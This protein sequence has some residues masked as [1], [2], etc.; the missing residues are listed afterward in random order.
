MKHVLS[1]G[2]AFFF[3][4]ITS[5]LHAEMTNQVCMATPGWP[6]DRSDLEA[7]PSLVRG[8]LNNGMRYV[9]KEN[10]EPK[11]RVAMY[12]LINAGSLNEL[13]SQRGVA[14]FLEHMLFNGSTHFKPGE[15]VKFFQDIG[16]NFG[17]DTNAFTSFDQTAYNI[18]LPDGTS[19]NL[20]KGFLVLSD[21]ARRALLLESE[22]DRERGVILSEKRSRDSVGYRA[23][24]KASEFKYD[25]T[26]LATRQPIGLESVIKDADRELLKSFYDTW[27]RTDNMVVV[28]VGDVSSEQVKPLLEDAFS[29]LESPEDAP[30]C[31]DFGA[32][33]HAEDKAYY[34]YDPDLGSTNVSIDSIW[35]LTRRNDSKAMQ[36]EEVIR[37]A[38][39]MMMQRRLNKLQESEGELFSGIG[40]YSGDMVRKLGYSTLSA[41]VVNGKWQEGLEYLEN[42][43]RQ[44]LEYG[45]QEQEFELVKKE[46][47]SMLERAVLTADTKPSQKIARSIMRAFVSD[48]V[49]MSPQQELDLYSAMLDDLTMTEINAGIRKDWSQGNRLVSV[50]G[51]T[52]IA[53]NKAEAKILDQYLLAK[54]K[55]VT[56]YKEDIVG[57]FPYLTIPDV[58]DSIVKE[59]H[60][61]ESIDAERIIYA[62]NVSLILKPTEFNANT[63]QLVLDFGSGKLSEP[64]PGM[65]MLA[66]DIV[67]DS[68]T[69][70][71]TSTALDELLAGT[72][73]QLNFEVREDSFRLSGSSLTKDS[74]LLFQLL[75]TLLNDPG[76]RERSYTIARNQLKE[77]YDSIA[78]EAEGAKASGVERFFAGGDERVG[79]P[80]WEDVEAISLKEIEAWLVPQFAAGGVEVAVVGDFDPERIK[81]LARTY[82]G[83]L[84][85]REP[86]SGTSSTLTFPRGQQHVELVNSQIDKS[87]VVVAWPTDDF[88]DINR[89]RR[90]NVLAGIFRERLRQVVREKLG[91]TYSPV[92]FSAPSRV[93]TDYG[94]LQAEVVVAPGKEN[95][96]IK[97]ITTIA[98]ELST[99]PVPKEELDRVIEPYLTS[100]RDAVN[101]NPYWL[102]SVLANSTRHPEQLEWPASILTDFQGITTGD[103]ES[104]A[105]QYLLPDAAAT[106]VIK[107]AESKNNAQADTGKPAD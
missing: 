35:N 83:G 52:E 98:R 55:A 68:G 24:V 82:L 89:T 6:S 2:V 105:K 47:I 50:E 97:E 22:I 19:E 5:S 16:M 1:I 13:E 80:P 70:N 64:K 25:G 26:L 74:E 18:I 15:L 17:G 38:N 54:T 61:I 99:K 21:Y 30:V 33:I 87:I 49:I 8:T 43:L 53:G 71:L 66:N 88:W 95:E 37:V 57:E 85:K 75:Y 59:Q 76:F 45:F 81:E 23:R 90:L 48:R 100:L 72:T 78:N 20:E 41:S 10:S 102:R 60:R 28:V 11:S 12:L 4:V 58:D 96:I 103:V 106:A 27:Y 91:A 104:L 84:E 31:L 34:H 65:G 29:P 77:M 93:Y 56:P 39:I 101:S 3:L 107:Q 51:S 73:V 42:Y 67:N 9:I 44:V 86:I 94:R 36:R 32:V 62:N 40:Y 46:L 63:I 79:L 92:V 14:H 69:A 7:D